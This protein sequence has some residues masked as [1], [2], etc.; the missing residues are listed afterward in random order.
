VAVLRAA[1]SLTQVAT[2]HP[3]WR[4]HQHKGKRPCPWSI[5]VTGNYRLIF[6]YDYSTH[7]ISGMYYDDPH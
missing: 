4:V 7:E 6:F 3:S 1:T 5:D 2:A